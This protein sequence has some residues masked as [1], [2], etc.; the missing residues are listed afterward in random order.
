MCNNEREDEEG[1]DGIDRGDR[2]IR[3]CERGERKGRMYGT[4]SSHGMR[5]STSA[6]RDI[7]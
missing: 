1:E 6:H 7:Q 5:H 3:A 2:E 4:L